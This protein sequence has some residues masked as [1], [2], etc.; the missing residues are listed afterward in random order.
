MITIKREE[1]K[2]KVIIK[3]GIDSWY[4]ELTIHEDYELN[5]ILKERQLNNHL[6]ETIEK[7]RRDAYNLG[8]KDKA[9]KKNKKRTWF[10]G[11]INSDHV[12]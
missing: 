7:I 4:S 2:I 6:Y 8:W 5:A 11:N 3:Y 12:G 10:S 9:S 1:N